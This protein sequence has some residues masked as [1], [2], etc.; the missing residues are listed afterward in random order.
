MRTSSPV[1]SAGAQRMGGGLAPWLVILQ[2]DRLDWVL[3]ASFLLLGFA[4]EKVRWCASFL[5]GKEALRATPHLPL[6]VS[7]WTLTHAG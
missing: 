6:N 1:G 7:I 2:K 3:V 4:A 5:L